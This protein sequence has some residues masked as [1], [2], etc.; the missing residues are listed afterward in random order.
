MG[1]GFFDGKVEG[2]E[3]LGEVVGSVDGPTVGLTVGRFDGVK[4]E[5]PRTP[6]TA[7]TQTQQACI[8]VSNKS[9]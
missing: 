6:V 5:P 3:T 7:S 8:A 4:H 9:K 2:E 1:L